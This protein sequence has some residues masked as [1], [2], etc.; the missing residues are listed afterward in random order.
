MKT[1]TVTFTH[2]QAAH[3]M[4]AARAQRPHVGPTAMMALDRAANVLQDELAL[5]GGLMSAAQIEA[6]A[7]SVDDMLMLEAARVLEEK[8]AEITSLKAKV[9]DLEAALLLAADRARPLGNF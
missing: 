7:P 2:D 8:S 6:P 1:L 3:L 4:I 9:R 5:Q